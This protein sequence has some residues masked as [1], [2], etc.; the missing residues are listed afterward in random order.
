[1]YK[2]VS[3]DDILLA[4]NETVSKASKDRVDEYM[5][6]VY[7]VWNE[8]PPLSPDRWYELTQLIHKNKDKE[9]VHV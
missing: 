2:L 3:Y 1:M 8:L 4:L 7:E 9:V 5:N 6:F